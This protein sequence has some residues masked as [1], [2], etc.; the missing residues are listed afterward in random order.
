M[1]FIRRVL[2]SVFCTAL[3]RGIVLAF[4]LD[5]KVATALRIAMTPAWKETMAWL[6]AGGFGLI[7]L[8]AWE[9]RHKLIPATHQG[10]TLAGRP[11][12]PVAVPNA[13]AIRVGDREPHRVFPDAL[14][15][16]NTPVTVRVEVRNI[17]HQL[18]LTDCQI[19]ESMEPEEIPAPFVLRDDFSLDAGQPNYTDVAFRYGAVDDQSFPIMLNRAGHMSAS[20]SGDSYILKFRATAAQTRSCDLECQLYIDEARMLRLKKIS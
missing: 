5:E 2:V 17:H 12:L 4:G 3:G 1:W 7:G 18:C 10:V 6:L 19:V 11:P 9:L 15:D 14:S 13:L 16:G 8:V 20:L